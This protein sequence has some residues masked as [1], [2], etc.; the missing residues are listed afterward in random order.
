VILQTYEN[1]ELVVVNNC[2]TDRTLEIASEY[3]ARDTR[4][5]VCTNQRFV[6]AIE[7]YNIALRH[8]SQ[9]EQ[10]ALNRCCLAIYSSEWAA[11]TALRHYAVD[12]RKVKVVPFG[13]NV[14]GLQSPD[15]V[16]RITSGKSA[17]VCRL[18]FVGVDWIRKGETSRFQSRNS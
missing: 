9:V 6:R 1:W 17:D 5:R 3:S 7:N 11:S 14:D 15:E 10:A 4:I 2:S 18:L 13:A 16:A 8:I 12:A